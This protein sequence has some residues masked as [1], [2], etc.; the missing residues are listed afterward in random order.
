[1]YILTGEFNVNDRNNNNATVTLQSGDEILAYEDCGSNGETNSYR[2]YAIK[3]NKTNMWEKVRYI[4]TTKSSN[5]DTSVIRKVGELTKDQ[6]ENINAYR[7]TYRGGR[8]KIRKQR[9]R[10]TRH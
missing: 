8:R 7:K 10:R 3:Q 5:L 2:I 1:M 9:T 4:G 6:K